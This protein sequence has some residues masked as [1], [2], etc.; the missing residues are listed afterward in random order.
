MSVEQDTANV[1]INGEPRRVERLPLG[2]LLEN[3]GFGGQGRGIAVALNGRVI[4]RSNWMDERP[5]DGDTI[6]IVG[7]VQG[8]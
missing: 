2:E 4:P 5:Q 3:L 8:G 7:A 1:T 6:E